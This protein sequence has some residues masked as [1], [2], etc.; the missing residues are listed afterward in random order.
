MQVKDSR[1]NDLP[2]ENQ[3]KKLELR[4]LILRAQL[5]AS[6]DG[7]IVADIDGNLILYNQRF[8]EIWQIPEDRFLAADN[9]KRLEM[10][11]AK[12]KDPIRSAIQI[13]S[14][15]SRP[16]KN[17][18]DEVELAD[19]RYL[20]RYTSSVLDHQGQIIGR[21]WFHRDITELKRI[22]KELQEYNH[23]LGQQ[24]KER[25]AELEKLYY[26]LQIKESHNEIQRKKLEENNKQLRH[27]LYY[28]ERGKQN[29]QEKIQSNIKNG[30]MPFLEILRDT[31]LSKKQQE[32]LDEIDKKIN[33][34]IN[35]TNG[36]EN[37]LKN[38]LSP[39]EFKVAEYITEGKNSK[40]IASILS[41]SKRTIEGHRYSIRKKLGLKKGENLHLHLRSIFRR[42]ET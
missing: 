9:H 41:C 17:G 27:I 39:T 8:F 40:E 18:H 16:E 37:T 30:L 11:L 22:Q 32:I 28:M 7:I 38:S 5:E 1:Q 34:L 33:K 26:E 10:A 13:W 2:D 21:I 35:N 29:L 31:R 36:K 19:G 20:D 4:Y 3:L 42:M 14:M 25:T 24:V 23:F 12:T 6:R 15:M